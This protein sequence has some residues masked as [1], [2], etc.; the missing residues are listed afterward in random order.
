MLKYLYDSDTCQNNYIYY[1][2]NFYSLVY[3]EIEKPY[4]CISTVD[5]EHDSNN[6]CS[7][8][9]SLKNYQLL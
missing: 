9:E 4:L 7:M 3:T 8:N 1:V 5:D 6:Y 2:K